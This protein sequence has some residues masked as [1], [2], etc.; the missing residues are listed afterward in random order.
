MWHHV[1]H[2]SHAK[3]RW[4]CDIV[5]YIV[6]NYVILFQLCYM[7][8]ANCLIFFCF[9]NITTLNMHLFSDCCQNTAHSVSDYSLNRCW[10]C[11]FCFLTAFFYTKSPLYTQY[12]GQLL[13]VNLKV[14]KSMSSLWHNI[15]KYVLERLEVWS[16][17][18]LLPKVYVENL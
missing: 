16:L 11:C 18:L 7:W 12:K 8:E 13:I 17:V 4:L 9:P 14:V 2:S 1:P 10:S 3:N 15:L 5:W 6:W